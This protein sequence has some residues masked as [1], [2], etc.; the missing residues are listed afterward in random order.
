MCACKSGW[1]GCENGSIRGSVVEITAKN[2]AR[3]ELLRAM[4]QMA[5]YVN[6]TANGDAHLLASS[7]FI[8]VGQSQAMRIPHVP[9]YGMLED[10]ERNG[11]PEL[12]L[13]AHP[14]HLGIRVPVGD[15]RSVS[16]VSVC[17]DR[18]WRN[19]HCGYAVECYFEDMGI[20]VF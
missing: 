6:M 8:L 3:R 13:R 12:P 4:K 20:W 1:Y 2:N 17:A 9:L 16:K 18:Y 14:Q 15:D 11:D 10:G 5:F 7:G 19:G